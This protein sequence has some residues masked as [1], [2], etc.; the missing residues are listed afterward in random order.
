MRSANRWIDI[1]HVNDSKVNI[2][3]CVLNDEL[4]FESLVISVSLS[5]SLFLTHSLIRFLYLFYDDGAKRHDDDNNGS[6]SAQH[7]FS[8]FPSFPFHCA[9]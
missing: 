9:R 8:F 7:Y 5:L 3:L 6:L 1:T 4:I 2:I